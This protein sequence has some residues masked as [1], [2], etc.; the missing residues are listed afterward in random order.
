MDQAELD[1]VLRKT[2]ENADLWLEYK[3]L[4]DK[5]VNEYQLNV[6]FMRTIMVLGKPLLADFDQKSDVEDYP[7]LHDDPEKAVTA[8]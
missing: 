8:F 1:K 2:V 3:S 5:A 4:F 6:S 7:T